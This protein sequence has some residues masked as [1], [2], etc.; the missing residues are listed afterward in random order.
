[1]IRI[2]HHFWILIAFLTSLI[3]PFFLTTQEA[4]NLQLP[5]VT[6]LADAP[7]P[8][9]TLVGVPQVNKFQLN[10]AQGKGF[11]TTFDGDDGVGLK[12]EQE[13]KGIGTK[14]IQIFTKQLNGTLEQLDQSGTVFKLVFEKID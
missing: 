5:V 4:A 8:K 7:D 14:L 1:M 10:I 6:Y 2:P 13:S 11:F 9:I 12:Q 3:C